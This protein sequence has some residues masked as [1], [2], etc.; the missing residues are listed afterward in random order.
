MVPPT[1]CPIL[2]TQIPLIF[3]TT[4]PRRSAYSDVAMWQLHA[5]KCWS[6]AEHINA[7]R[8]IIHQL[9]VDG[10]SPG[11]L[12]R[13]TAGAGAALHGCG[14]GM[15]S[16]IQT[17]AARPPADGR[18]G[19]R[20]QVHLPP[21][22]LMMSITC[23]AGQPVKLGPTRPDVSQLVRQQPASQSVNR[24][25]CQS[26]S[27]PGSAGT[28]C[29]CCHRLEHSD[30]CA[31]LAAMQRA[32]SSTGGALPA[33]EAACNLTIDVA[34]CAVHKRQATGGRAQPRPFAPPL[35]AAP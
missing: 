11:A 27:H 32:P 22:R 5:V 12:C 33:L 14:M 6:A 26:V 16:N 15:Q 9:W 4:K 1:S 20:A 25:A 3:G 35:P 10:T 2:S 13:A 24:S 30:I 19:C 34:S 21:R 28:T 31:G 23:N 17:A 18:P 7:T 29:V 8:A